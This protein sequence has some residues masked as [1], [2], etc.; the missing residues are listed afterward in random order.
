MQTVEPAVAHCFYARNSASLRCRNV[1]QRR[2][3]A[4]EC[5]GFTTASNGPEERVAAQLSGWRAG[6]KGLAGLGTAIGHSPS[7][8]P[9]PTVR[10]LPC[11]AAAQR[12][13]RR[14]TLPCDPPA[15]VRAISGLVVRARARRCLLSW[16]VRSSAS[17]CGRPAPAEPPSASS[18]EQKA[19]NPG[20]P[21][22]PLSLFTAIHLVSS[23]RGRQ[24][25]AR[26]LSPGPAPR[27]RV[28][29]RP[30]PLTSFRRTQP[31]APSPLAGALPVPRKRRLPARRCP[32]RRP[33]PSNVVAAPA[34]VRLVPRGVQLRATETDA[35]PV[36]SINSHGLTLQTAA[37]KYTVA[38]QR[39]RL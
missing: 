4:S 38:R 39:A 26:S 27:R 2:T 11:R 25:T 1:R 22:R 6:T 17:E 20:Q 15:S 37:E 18:A 29:H 10:T 21:P 31:V 23:S 12:S 8:P 28:R 32:S 5:L 33:Q 30:A 3:H 19:A 34:C 9:L 14:P 24:G 7:S 13:Q 16:F 35:A 36:G